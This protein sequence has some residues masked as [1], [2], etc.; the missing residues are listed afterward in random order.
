MKEKKQ[1]I[2]KKY[3]VTTNVIKN[4]SIIVIL[5]GIM[6][7]S[8]SLMNMASTCLFV[9]GILLSVG[10]TIFVAEYYIN[11]LINHFKNQNQE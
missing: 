4:M 1:S 10:A 9:I 8:F 6:M 5:T 11:K 3:N 2:F 7:C